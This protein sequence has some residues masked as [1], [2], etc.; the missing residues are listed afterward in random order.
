MRCLFCLSLGV[1]P[2]GNCWSWRRK[3]LRFAGLLI[4]ILALL[5][6]NVVGIRQKAALM[7]ANGERATELLNQVVTFVP[8][9]PEGGELV[10][11]NPPGQYVRYS[12]FLLPNF[13][14]LNYG[15]HRIKQLG[16]RNDFTIRVA[17]LAGLHPL[18]SDRKSLILTFLATT[19]WPCSK[20]QRVRSLKAND[21][22]RVLISGPRCNTRDY[23]QVVYAD[24]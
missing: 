4:L 16:E 6:S 18:R 11:L 3:S 2:L 24:D 15:L 8:E 22:L 21:L 7:R 5:A 19:G 13:H 20:S 14:V 1:R 10:L 12:T 9:V 23:S 17:D